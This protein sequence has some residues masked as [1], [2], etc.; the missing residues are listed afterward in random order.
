MIRS[1]NKRG[2]QFNITEVENFVKNST[3]LRQHENQEHLIEV[4]MEK[5]GMKE[6]R[7]AKFAFWN[8][9]RNG[10]RASCSVTPE[11]FQKVKLDA[12]IEEILRLD[13]EENNNKSEEKA[14]T[15]DKK[16]KKLSLATI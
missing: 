12:V 10:G 2:N 4:A 15:K 9:A 8:V 11:E 6:A 1:N 5:T 16:K 14:V 7:L 13:A 3:W